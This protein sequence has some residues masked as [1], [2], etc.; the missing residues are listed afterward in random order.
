MWIFLGKGCRC[1]RREKRAA[2][3]GVVARNERC[4]FEG[5]I[6]GIE[7]DWLGEG[8]SDAGLSYAAGVLNRVDF[9]D[10]RLD[11]LLAINGRV[12]GLVC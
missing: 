3:C 11:P 2:I 5:D 1:G 12:A 10:L 4:C 7:W 9:Y 6:L 8:L